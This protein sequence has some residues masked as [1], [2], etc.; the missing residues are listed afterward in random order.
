MLKSIAGRPLCYKSEINAFHVHIILSAIAFKP[1]FIYL[2][3]E[4]CIIPKFWSISS[5]KQIIFFPTQFDALALRVYQWI[6]SIKKSYLSFNFVY[7]YAAVTN[8]LLFQIRRIVG[9]YWTIVTVITINE[10]VD[11]FNLFSLISLEFNISAQ[12]FTW[13]NQKSWRQWIIGRSSKRQRIADAHPRAWIDCLSICW[14]YW[15]VVWLKR[16]KCGKTKEYIGG[17]KAYTRRNSLL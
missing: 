9:G 6:V 3:E 17:L 14:R 10:D 16:S 4:R 15:L 12:T 2:S 1:D 5:G 8:F 13:M 7:G 11:A